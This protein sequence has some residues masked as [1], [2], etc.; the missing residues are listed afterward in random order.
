MQ[1]SDIE[2]LIESHGNYSMKM[3]FPYHISKHSASFYG[4]LVDRGVHGSLAGTDV[5]I[6]E[7]LGESLSHWN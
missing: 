5:H 6:L 1:D 2:E 4:S 3:A 7:R